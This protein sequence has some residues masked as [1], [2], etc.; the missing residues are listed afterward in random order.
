MR[1]RPFRPELLLVFPAA[2][3]LLCLRAYY[4]G[5][6]NDDALYIIGAR[7]FLR[8]GRYVELHAPDLRPFYTHPPGYALLLAAW[9]ALTGDTLLGYQLLSVALTLASVW[10]LWRLS[11][12]TC[13]AAAFALSPATVTLSGVVLSEVPFIAV[14]LAALAAA[15]KW[16][17]VRSWKVWAGLGLLAGYLVH[18]RLSGAA[19]VVALA[20]CLAWE[21]RWREAAVSGAASLVVFLPHLVRVRLALGQSETRIVEM[22]E[23]YGSN[24][25]GGLL[26]AAVAG[27]PYYVGELFGRELFRAPGVL[28]GIL[29]AA[30]AA[31]AILGARARGLSGPR[32]LAALFFAVYAAVHLAWPYRSG[33]Y[34]YP[35][36]PLACL[37]LFAGLAA[38]EERFKRRGLA[39]AAL[40]LSVFLGA[41]PIGKAIGAAT[42]RDTPL[43]RG[44][45][46]TSAWIREHTPPEAVFAANYDGRLWLLTGRRCLHLPTAGGADALPA[47][48]RDN[49]VDYVLAEDLAG[50]MRRTAAGESRRPL[51][52][53]E[54]EA[55]LG[56]DAKVF[57]DAA[58][59]AAVF[60]VR[61]R[62]AP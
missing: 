7:A 31:V 1:A 22:L 39:L 45:D 24:P 14:S 23:P 18:V 27:V 44:P 2:L 48:L 20:G 53:S 16:W 56:L 42:R 25:A 51:E 61:P 5:F 46:R 57:S 33:R 38:L 36:L 10:L 62:V 4:V 29:A 55:R 8:L 3:Y 41:F 60:R 11:G 47:W 34:A 58:E 32:K 52:A 35:V 26:S 37:F 13:A 9:G 15:E 21:R 12:S 30:A 54:L 40:A 43:T 19:L 59:G 6:F 50:Y 49:R 28:G 17:S